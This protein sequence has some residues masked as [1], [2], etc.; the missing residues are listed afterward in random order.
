VADDN[1]PAEWF[2]SSYR[3]VQEEHPML[4]MGRPHLALLIIIAGVPLGLIMKYVGLIAAVL[5][6][7]P[8]LGIAYWAMSLIYKNDQYWLEHLVSHYYPDDFYY[9]E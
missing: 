3:V 7:A 9:G 1:L 6:A 8:I 2:V 5:M 4:G